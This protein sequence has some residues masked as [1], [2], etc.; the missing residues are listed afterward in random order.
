[1]SNLFPFSFYLKEDLPENNIYNNFSKYERDL[2]TIILSFQQLIPGEITPFQLG[3][4]NLEILFKER[5]QENE[6]IREHVNVNRV[7]INDVKIY[8]LRNFEIAQELAESENLPLGTIILLADY[9]N[10]YQKQIDLD[11]SAVNFINYFR[12]Q[13]LRTREFI[14]RLNGIVDFKRIIHN[15]SALLWIMVRKSPN[16]CLKT[17]VVDLLN[18]FQLHYN[19]PELSTPE[20]VNV[21]V[22][23]QNYLTSNRKTCLSLLKK[24]KIEVPSGLKELSQL[25]NTDPLQSRKMIHKNIDNLMTI[26]SD[27]RHLSPKD[28][29]NI[30]FKMPL[31]EIE[32]WCQE[33]KLLLNYWEAQIFD[34]NPNSD[35]QCITEDNNTEGDTQLEIPENTIEVE[36][37]VETLTRFRAR[38][39]SYQVEPIFQFYAIYQW[40]RWSRKTRDKKEQLKFLQISSETKDQLINPYLLEYLI[41]TEKVSYY[42][43]NENY[44]YPDLNLS[45][46]DCERVAPNHIIPT[47]TNSRQLMFFG[48][49][50][51]PICTDDIVSKYNVILLTV[52]ISKSDTNVQIPIELE[53]LDSILTV[54]GFLVVQIPLVLLRNS[55][56]LTILDREFEKSHLV[57]VNYLKWELK[58]IERFIHKTTLQCAY[59]VYQK[60]D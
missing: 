48:K 53:F 51:W 21:N 55:Q 19:L 22:A 45:Y 27:H 34:S 8:L 60:T 54:D 47:I 13:Q 1:M 11:T 16:R 10:N 18:F 52:D 31:E 7:K 32:N 46:I 15:N 5:S 3:L 28:L 23:G 58:Q 50:H 44:D 41:T 43:Y 39:S 20:N 26:F 33:I 25:C 40:I 4:P 24:G 49:N 56:T 35:G 42:Y 37:L 36:E 9:S 2:A 14:S 30:A 29:E 12:K 57:R 59:L 6:K 38:Y 17:R